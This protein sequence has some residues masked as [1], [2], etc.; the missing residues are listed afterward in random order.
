MPIGVSTS[1]VVPFEFSTAPTFICGTP[2]NFTLTVTTNQGVFVLNFTKQTC[3]APPVTVSG[4]IVPGDLQ[5]NL[6][7]NR[8]GVPS[9]CANKVF[10]GTA[11]GV[12]GTRSYDQ[13]SFTN[14]SNGTACL[15]IAH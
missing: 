8:N 1:N 11:A 14:N 4:T 7:V 6:R 10:P 3:E 12:T 9:T 5:Q 15:S 13:Y 2:I